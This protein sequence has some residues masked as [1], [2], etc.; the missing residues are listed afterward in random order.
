MDHEIQLFSMLPEHVHPPLTERE[1]H[2]S[3]RY[4]LALIEIRDL[5]TT[6][7]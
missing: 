6:C 5:T 3:Q 7:S 1:K 4:L 2:V